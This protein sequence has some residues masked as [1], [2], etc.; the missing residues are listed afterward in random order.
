MDSATPLMQVAVVEKG[1]AIAAESAV[2]HAVDL[3]SP[4]VENLMARGEFNF[5][6]ADGMICCSGPGSSMGLKSALISAKVWKIFS[7]KALILLQYCSLDMCLR[8]NRDANTVCVPWRGDVFIAKSADCDAVTRV[9]RSELQ[10]RVGTLL[11]NSRRTR[12][13][14]CES[15]PDANYCITAADF[16]ILSICSEFSGELKD[17]GEFCYEKCATAAGA[18]ND[19]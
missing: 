9:H 19:D 14:E 3:L 5:A 6:D 8:L 13:A 11:L 4:L 1:R 12:P 7:P 17:Y 18:W 15:F 10:S 2:G 16:D